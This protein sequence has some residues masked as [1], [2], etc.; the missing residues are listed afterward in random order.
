MKNWYMMTQAEREKAIHQHKRL[1][2]PL[3][4]LETI[5]N[6]FEVCWSGGLPDRCIECSYH[7]HG[8]VRELEADALDIINVQA[9]RIKELEEALNRG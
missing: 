5:R 8:C 6:D 2:T 9:A 7:N 4:D 3:P 1:T